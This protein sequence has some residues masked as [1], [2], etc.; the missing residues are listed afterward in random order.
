M[1]SDEWY[2]VKNGQKKG[3]VSASGLKAL[4]QQKTL[5]PEDMVFRNGEKKW[6]SAKSVKG[7]FDEKNTSAVPDYPAVPPP[8]PNPA[9]SLSINTTP[10][11]SQTPPTV[12]AV[13]PP[14][15]ENR[16]QVKMP[17]ATKS[18]LAAW[19]S[20][21]EIETVKSPSADTDKHLLKNLP[22]T[23]HPID[24]L[25][26]FFQKQ[27]SHAMLHFLES[28]VVFI[29][30]FAVLAGAMLIPIFCYWITYKLSQNMPLSSTDFFAVSSLSGILAITVLLLV[31]QFVTYRL[32]REIK[33]WNAG[34]P[35]TLSTS[36]VCD[37]A[38]AIF[39]FFGVAM[40]VSWT[41]SGLS[42]GEYLSSIFTGMWIFFG[43]IY[44][45]FSA[46][47][48]ATFS[49]R[50]VAENTVTEEIHGVC[51]FLIK[52][53]T[54]RGSLMLY[55]IMSVIVLMHAC[56]NFFTLETLRTEVPGIWVSTLKD[57]QLQSWLLLIA[58]M[59]PAVGHILFQILIYFLQAFHSLIDG[60]RGVKT[61]VEE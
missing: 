28:V 57:L 29:G 46:L 42:K 19:Q 1:A 10:S 12:P 34:T 22:K 50:I 47:H 5:A 58:A 43:C 61:D 52:L 54:Q 11:F 27:F 35:A 13:S 7:L 2:Y 39:I 21:S 60:N 26:V 36:S 38:S 53:F 40:L 30:H 41:L 14:V 25:L 3:P 9:V 15:Q 37:V 55:G 51:V 4:A 6:I 31:F 20:S 23:R 24:F 45:A 59:A 17:A 16:E 56:V 49:I 8:V 48:P 32:I 18:A 33:F 44:L